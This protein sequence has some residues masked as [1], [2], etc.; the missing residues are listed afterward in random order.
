MRRF[1]I[2]GGAGFIGSHFVR[3]AIAEGWADEVHVLDALT[4]A[5][6]LENLESVKDHPSFYFTKVDIR[7]AEA[8][9]A[10]IPDSVDGLFHFAA[11]SHVDRSI[12]SAA[13]FV[14]TNVVG[15]QLLL[16][17]SRQKGVGRFMHIST[18]EVYGAL[19]L[20][21]PERFHEELPLEP[22]S[23][24]AASKAAS[25]LMVLAAHKTH[26]MDVV[27][28]RSSN[29][30]GPYQF[31]EKFIPLFISNAL[32]SEPLPLYGD[33][34]YIR[35][36]IHVDDHVAGIYLAFQK[37]V[38]G[39]VYNLGGDCER[40]NRQIAEAICAATGQET[41]LIKTVK[42]RLAHDRRYAIDAT[43]ARRE[44]GFVPGGMIEERMAEIVKWYEANRGWW[45]RIK[46]G[47]YQNY[48]EEHYGQLDTKR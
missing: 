1:V 26:E 24:Y 39:E 46:A 12:K 37:G 36:W 34:R 28:T 41:S 9:E 22:T 17:L 30:Y 8:L 27:I 19:E 21:S 23:P 40:E 33:G 7:D 25:D 38:S 2:T 4:Y 6:N 14:E 45:E 11:E 43:K 5:G 44:L 31:P 35:D 20:D 47:D 42:D 3:C 48:Y 18:D 15:T 29:N 10:A 16:D 32:N 13:A